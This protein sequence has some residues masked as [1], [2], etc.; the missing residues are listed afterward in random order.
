MTDSSLL[1]A[2][3]DVTSQ[4]LSVMAIPSAD[5]PIWEISEEE[6]HATLVYLGEYSDEDR[7]EE[8]KEWVAQIAATAEPFE[9]VVSGLEPLGD[10][11][12]VWMLAESDLNGLHEGVMNSQVVSAIYEAADITKY[13]KYT[14]HVTA[15]YEG[16]VTE[17]MES[18]SEITFDRIS[19]WHGSERTDY[20]LGASMDDEQV[21]E[22]LEE[23]VEDEEIRAGDEGVV[24]WHGV[25]A[26]EGR[27]SGDGRYFEP[28]SLTH[29]VMSDRNGLPLTWQEESADGHDKAATTGGIAGMGRDPEGRI[30][31]W[32][33]IRQTAKSDEFTGFIAEFGKVGVSIDADDAVMSYDEERDLRSFAYGRIASACA[34]N[35]PALPHA[36]IGLGEIPEETLNSL[37]PL[38]EAE[39]S[40][41]ESAEAEGMSVSEFLG[42]EEEVVDEPVAAAS[43]VD[44]MVASIRERAQAFKRGPGWITHPKETRRLHKYWTTPGQPGY[45]KIGWGTPGDFN[46]CRVQ[47]GEKIA[48]NSPE[49]VRFLN[50]ICA[51]WHHDALGIWP[52]EHHAAEG[53]RP[54][55][56]SLISLSASAG[57][58]VPSEWFQRPEDLSPGGITITDEGR[59][60]GYIAEW[61]VCHI[62]IEG[63][64][65]EA[66]Q[67]MAD[68]AYFATGIV[69]T[70]DGEVVPVGALT[71]DTGHANGRAGARAAASHYD[72]TGTQWAYV[73]VGEDE[74][75]IWYSGMVKPGT[76]EETLKSI[77]ATGRLSGDWRGIQG[78]LELVAALTV[79]VP[80]FP[81]IAPQAVVASGEQV[82]LIAAGMAKEQAAEDPSAPMNE[83]A[84]AIV[85]EMEARQDRRSRL[86]AVRNQIEGQK[87]GV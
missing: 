37:S 29:R 50:Q 68:Y 75:G 64:C 46:R 80:G 1:A 82:A 41:R 58:D 31:G 79:N 36:W 62:G 24:P 57:W 17:E 53:T 45:A 63:V 87:N 6:V 48:K 67:S 85:D 16:E 66:P 51:Q 73:S 32:G 22:I 26:V 25:L 4:T 38:S 60:F 35:I 34:V 28:G 47:V 12:A 44:A 42:L 78:N 20:P 40:V 54:E 55:G 13:P 69:K 52:G 19:V 15:T 43:D 27:D 8:I 76:T 84:A 61:G 77:M 33:W 81:V 30:W 71:V 59:V 39:S 83:L 21:D 10:A 14:A 2:A 72:D 49:D 23:E 18:V 86:A 3:P 74:H 70:N 65:T 11:K 9:A 7:I 56:S 5:S